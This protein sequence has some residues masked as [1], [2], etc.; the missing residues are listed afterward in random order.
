MNLTSLCLQTELEGKILLI[1]TSA[2]RAIVFLNAKQLNFVHTLCLF[3]LNSGFYSAH[4]NPIMI[5]AF[6]TIVDAAMKRTW[7]TEQPNFYFVLCGK[8]GEMRNGTDEC[9]NPELNVR[10]VL[11]D[12]YLQIVN[13]SI[14]LLL[15]PFSFFFL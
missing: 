10:V 13:S 9:W 6:Q 3:R 1:I 8:T 5:K 15:P 4:S 2:I 11:L 14:V 7:E 12:R